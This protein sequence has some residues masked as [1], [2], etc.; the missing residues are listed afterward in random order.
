[1]TVLSHNLYRLLAKN[2]PGYTHNTST[3]LFE[4]F[5][6]NSGEIK[7][8]SDTIRV[9]MKKKRNPPVLLTE[10]EKSQDS[11]LPWMENK[12]IYFC[13]ASSS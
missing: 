4:K 3:S 13:G 12:K 5:V 9:K 1:M 2:L 6:S 11:I 10:M 7:I 8:S